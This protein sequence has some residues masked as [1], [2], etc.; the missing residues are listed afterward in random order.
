MGSRFSVSYG[1]QPRRASHRKIQ[2]QRTRG[3]EGVCFAVNRACNR[4][5]VLTYRGIS[6]EGV[7]TELQPE[8]VIGGIHVRRVLC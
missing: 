7:G 4:W 2:R 1:L 3:A 6:S 5:I 8:D